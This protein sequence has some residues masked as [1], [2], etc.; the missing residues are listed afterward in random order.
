[1]FHFLVSGESQGM[2]SKR[3]TLR[4]QNVLVG[5][6][7]S[8]D[9]AKLIIERLLQSQQQVITA[10]KDVYNFIVRYIWN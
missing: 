1:L 5:V 10:N 2:P 9:Y 4:P 3:P 6:L 7:G 8:G